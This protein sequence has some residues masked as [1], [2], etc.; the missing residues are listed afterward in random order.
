[1]KK[2]ILQHCTKEQK[3]LMGLSGP[4]NM[5]YAKKLGF[6]FIGNDVR[7]CPERSIYW[8]KIAYLKFMLPKFEDGS[9]VV[10]E[11]ADS[12][13]LK[14]ESFELALPEG[15]VL[16][17]VQN[18]GGLNHKQLISWYNAGIIVMINS[19]LIRNFFDRVWVRPD[20]TDEAAIVAE[21]REHG[22]EVGD[23]NYVTSLNCKWNC[24]PNNDNM[25][26]DPVV[27]SWHGIKLP[28]KLTAMQD[29]LKTRRL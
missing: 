21:L 29:F 16:G 15:G 14:R 26:S 18:R 19:P 10:W 6:E 5:A 22:W 8:E 23:G 7:R 12:I 9:L 24:W 20:D 28:D 3:D 2:I 11:D 27:K 25:C 4:I 17:M 1:M 13:N